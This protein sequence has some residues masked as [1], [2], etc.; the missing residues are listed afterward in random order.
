MKSFRKFIAED[1]DAP[2]KKKREL[3]MDQNGEYYVESESCDIITPKV[4]KEFERVVDNLFKN[5]LGIDF[6]FTKHF[7]ERM[8]DGRN[9]PCIRLEELAATL[10]KIYRDVRAQKSIKSLEG[11]EAVINDIQNDL[12]MP[13]AIK[14]DSKDDELDVVMKTIMRKKNFTTPNVK[15]KV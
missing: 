7:G 14:W 8:S 6:K 15:I 13:I 9:K 4:M 11:A 5:K 12:N 2:K 10:K 3:K 1:K